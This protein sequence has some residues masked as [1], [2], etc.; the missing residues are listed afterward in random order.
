MDFSVIFLI[1]IIITILF[2]LIAAIFDVRLSF[3]PDELN[4][5][6][7]IFGLT[8]NLILSIFLK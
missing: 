4:F 1:Q 5:S 8:S 2:C 7:L 6:L 3:I